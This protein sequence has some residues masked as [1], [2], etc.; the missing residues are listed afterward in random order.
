[1]HVLLLP[2][3][4]RNA[5]LV[6]GS[7]SFCQRDD[8]EQYFK[9]C[10]YITLIIGRHKHIFLYTSR[11]AYQK[12]P[13]YRYEMLSALI[14]RRRGKSSTVLAG[15]ERMPRGSQTH[16]SLRLACDATVSRCPG[17]RDGRCVSEHQRRS[18]TAIYASESFAAP[19]LASTLALIVI[20]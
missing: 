16:H 18:T 13:D 19:N 2:P 11:I 12:A 8:R 10:D 17:G 7:Y 3:C 20:V 4:R 14:I 9:R 15:E 6:A 5:T 1:V